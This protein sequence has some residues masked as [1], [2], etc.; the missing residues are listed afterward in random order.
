MTKK[1]TVLMT[2]AN[3]VGP[4]M[5]SIGIGEVLR[6]SGHRV[7]FAVRASWRPKL[8]ALGFVVELL[9][10]E[11]EVV[12]DTVEDSLELIKNMISNRTPLEKGLN[13]FTTEMMADLIAIG[14]ADEPYY[15]QIIDRHKPD[16]IIS[17][18]VINMPSVV[19]SG[20]VWIMSNSN[21]PLSLDMCLEDNRLP[22]SLLGLPINDKS[23]WDDYRR[24]IN[25]TRF[26]AFKVWAD[27]LQ[28]HGCPAP[29][30]NQLWFPSPYA[31]FYLIPKELDYTDIRPL[32][33]NFYQ[34]DYYKRTANEDVFEIPE[35]LR[36]KSGKLIYL[37]LGS[38]GSADVD[39]MKRLVAMLANSEHRF[40]VSKGVNHDKY[41]L[42]DNMWGERFVP[43][44]K[45]LSIVD[46][47]L[48]HGGNNS[49]T[50]C[51]YFGKPMLVF[52]LFFDQFDNAQR[53][54]DKGYGIRLNPYECSEQQLLQSIDKILNDNKLIEKLRQVS[55]RIQ[56]EKLIEK[57][58]E[59][60]D[61]LVK[62]K[63]K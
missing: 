56:T 13:T 15:R 35:Q 42:A 10:G 30:A 62:Q 38:M 26:Q 44:V 9:G 24:Q 49:I 60:I 19:N 53:V 41:E 57:I 33:D 51:M 1:L 45:V 36:Q 27:W 5:S 59:I 25:E 4:I 61:R 12:K 34:F 6:D 23:L 48:T 3:F 21:N 7:V 63:S 43:Q 46:L 50:E 54:E 17:D 16:A 31:N 29:A 2:P 55:Q 14:E 32:P 18:N 28:S 37:S 8:Q 52:P 47:F 20:S 40:I 58:P 11:Q 22:P 39:L